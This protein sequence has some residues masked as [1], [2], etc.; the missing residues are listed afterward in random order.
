M[1]STS[2]FIVQIMVT[3]SGHCKVDLLKRRKVPVPGKGYKIV[4]DEVDSL[5]EFEF[6]K[7]SDLVISSNKEL[8][9]D[10]SEFGMIHLE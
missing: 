1:G 5:A 8:S 3:D 2:K 9:I 7:D 6:P 4:D 10:C